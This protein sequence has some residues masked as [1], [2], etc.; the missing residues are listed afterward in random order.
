MIGKIEYLSIKVRKLNHL[1][2][3]YPWAL[4]ILQT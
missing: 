4:L 2:G 3:S 1:L